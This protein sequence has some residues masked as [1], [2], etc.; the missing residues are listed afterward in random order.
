MIARTIVPSCT[1]VNEVICAN[2]CEVKAS[3]K[4]RRRWKLTD[5]PLCPLVNDF[6]Q[7]EFEFV[8]ETFI[9]EIR[10]MPRLNSSHSFRVLQN[11]SLALQSAEISSSVRVRIWTHL[12]EF[13]GEEWFAISLLLE[14][15]AGEQCDDLLWLVGSESILE[16]QFRE[17]QFIRRI[18]LRLS[19][20]AIRSRG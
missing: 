11:C 7:S 5:H 19:T 18:D 16:N 20:S 4:A 2:G 12:L 15:E 9:G 3:D 10:S 8:V 6:D 1:S 14:Y 13:R 17:N